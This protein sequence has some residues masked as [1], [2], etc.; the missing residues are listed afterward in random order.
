MAKTA[1]RE[2]PTGSKRAMWN[3]YVQEG[4]P[5][6]REELILAHLPLVK[7]TVLRMVSSLASHAE[8][9]DLE[10]AGLFGLIDAVEKFNPSMGKDFA[11]YA[12][13]RIRGAILDE[14]RALDWVPRSVRDKA[15]KLETAYVQAEQALGRPPT[16]EELAKAL[17]M[18]QAQ[19]QTVMGEVSG[20]LCLSLEELLT[21]EEENLYIAPISAGSS[22]E[23]PSETAVWTEVRQLLVDAI[24]VLSDQERTVVTLYYYEELTL[25]EIGQV[26]SI[27]ES[28]V[29][30][31]HARTL[32]RLRSGL[33][34]RGV[35][36][37]QG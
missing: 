6:A 19:L 17:D 4:D 31:I 32:L 34:Q 13:F 1:V 29:C 15:R 10:S 27:S 23:S 18:S 14:L 2:N 30:Q 26:L 12:S 33:N 8:V 16:D 20:L 37:R 25:K 11:A 35:E 3:A 36:T 24:D 5:Q 7:A 28:R 21:S 9:D 22:T